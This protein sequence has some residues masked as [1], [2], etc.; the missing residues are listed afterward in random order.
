MKKNWLSITGIT[1]GL[2]IAAAMIFANQLGVDNNAVWGTK[3]YALFLLGIFILT[4]SL[5]YREDNFLGQLIHTKTGQLYLA[6]IITLGLVILA[7]VWW[8]S[9]GLWTVWPKTTNYYDLMASA[10]RH[11]QLE[12]E[13]KPDPALLALEDPYEPTNRE[14]IPVLWD[15]TLYEGKYY[16][17][18]G[19]VPALLLSIIKFFYVNEIGDNILTFFFIAGTFIFL[20][21]II[22]AL[23]KNYFQELPRRIILLSIALVGLIN[24]LPFVLIDPRIYE[25]AV[26]AGQFFFIG[27]LYFLFNTFNKPSITSLTLT[28][29]FFTFAIGSR[30][31]LLIPIAF[32]SLIVLIWAFQSRRAQTVAFVIALAFPLAFGGIS[33]AWYNYARFGSITDFGYQYQ[34][35]GFNIH[36]T[37]GQTFSPAY[38][39]PNLYKTLLNPYEIKDAFPLIKSTLWSPPNGF[40]E[41]ERSIYYYFAESITG[42]LI[43]T[44]FLIL[45]ILRKKKTL[46]WISS[47]LTGSSLLIFLTTQLF[48]YTTMRY[49]LDLIPAL[50]LLSLIGLWSGFDLLKTKP[51]AKFS[52]TILG[53]SLWAYT[54]AV[55]VLLTFSSNLPRFKTYNPELIQQLIQTFNNFLK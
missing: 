40:N 48:F 30:T 21:L 5:L 26:A 13:V 1:L 52:F 20:T 18:W 47:S 38:V 14:G 35:T 42:I 37:I 17:Y 50:A 16:L 19:P 54:I 36:E 29:L 39:A 4:A 34:L 32:T 22:L 7:Y 44:P 24:P 3:R 12:L 23:W 15:A 46:F 27:G 43:G 10:F 49:L 11:G 51:A 6:S 41:S 55:S 33:Y 45:A 2:G 9:L 25:A 31:I 28:G 53:F 8:V